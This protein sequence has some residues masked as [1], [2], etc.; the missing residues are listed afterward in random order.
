MKKERKKENR[1]LETS[2]QLHKM[3][4]KKERIKQKRN[5]EE[6]QQKKKEKETLVCS[7]HIFVWVLFLFYSYF[8]LFATKRTKIIKRN[9]LFTH[10][11]LIIII[12]IYLRNT[13]VEIAL[14]LQGEI[15]CCNKSQNKIA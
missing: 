5:S 1:R 12:R 7:R 14:L 8:F 3:S 13:K 6:A 9:A 2:R 4:E 10:F 11:A 15:F